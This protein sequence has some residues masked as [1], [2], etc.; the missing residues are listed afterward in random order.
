MR[1]KGYEIIIVSSGAIAFGMEK[2]GFKERPRTIPQKQAAA[3]VGQTSLM[4]NYER[5]FA[6]KRE[7]VG[8]VLLTHSDLSN[9]QRYLNASKTLFTLIN[10][11]VI[12]IINENDSVVVEEIKFGDND[13]LAALTANLVEADL[14]LILTDMDGLFDR[15]PRRKKGAH[16]IPLV[17][18]ID[19][20]IER[21]A[22]RGKN[23]T[24]TGGMATKIQAA[25]KAAAFGAPTIVAN[26][27]VEGIIQK[28]FEGEEVG[29]LFLPKKDK[30]GSRKHWIAFTLKSKGVLVVD[31]GAKEAILS[32]GKSLLPSGLLEVRGNFESG[33]AVSIQDSS[34]EE[35]AKGL[36]NYSS[37]EI[38]KI[39][40]LKSR[41]L[42][43]TLGY[44]YYDEIVHRDD[45][46]I[47]KQEPGVRSQEPE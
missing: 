20:Q 26:G 23:D 12:P 27:K 5:F 9:R 44:R 35:F 33:Q 43:A 30:L 16:L 29:T 46:V 7:K 47:L 6:Q 32:Q 42:E 34:G 37:S 41:D 4:W 18:E 31:N 11:G 8:Q 17:K 36:V 28:I 14:L 15:D 40:G 1:R 13:N 25:K 10:L 22:F 3:A 24:G 21:L 39:K 45:L 19:G 2:L 38:N